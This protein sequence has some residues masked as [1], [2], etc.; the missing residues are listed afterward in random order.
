MKIITLSRPKE[1]FNKNCSYEILL[2]NQIVA[3]LH[4]G[5]EKIIKHPTGA[6]L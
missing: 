4:N 2:D 6:R 5:E 3:T 1:N